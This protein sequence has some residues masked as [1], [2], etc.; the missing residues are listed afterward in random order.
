MQDIKRRAA[1]TSIATS[2]GFTL[3]KGVIGPTAGSLAIP[4][5]A[6]HSLLDLAATIVTSLTRRVSGRPAGAE[7]GG[8]Q[9]T[10]SHFLNCAPTSSPRPDH[11]GACEQN[12]ASAPASS[13]NS[14]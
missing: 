14:G 3:A 10:Q 2:G 11:S 6:A 9:G 5:E 1:P 4:S 12:R 13:A 8:Q 7:Q